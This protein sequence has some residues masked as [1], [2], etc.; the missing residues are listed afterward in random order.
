[1]LRNVRTFR[2]IAI[3]L[4]ELGP[5]TYKCLQEKLNGMQMLVDGQDG[6]DEV[7]EL[8]MGTRALATKYL[9]QLMT[10]NMAYLE[11]L[12]QRDIAGVLDFLPLVHSGEG[13]EWAEQ[14][15]QARQEWR[16]ARE[17]QGRR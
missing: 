5:Q 4:K 17:L 7:N 16:E 11:G 14:A 13:E 3:V 12:R 8:V 1:M 10:G 9:H 6:E 2:Q 15:K